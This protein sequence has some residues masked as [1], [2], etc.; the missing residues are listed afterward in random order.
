MTMK[1]R[2]FNQLEKMYQ[3]CIAIME[4]IECDQKLLHMGNC[5]INNRLKK[6]LGRTFMG[7]GN[8]EISGE[9]FSYATKDDIMNTILHELCHRVNINTNDHHGDNWKHYAK[10]VTEKTGLLIQQYASLE[11]LSYRENMNG[12]ATVECATCGHK[13]IIKLSKTNE[14]KRNADTICKNFRCG[15]GGALVQIHK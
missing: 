4:T 14:K 12:Y 6:T 11:K 3:E 7:S 2:D 10:L 13:H 5:S 9:Y 15:C 1:K 8:I